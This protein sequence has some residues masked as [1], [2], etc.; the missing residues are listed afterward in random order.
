MEELHSKKVIFHR[1]HEKKKIESMRD[2]FERKDID[3]NI[4]Y[5]H[6]LPKR[7]YKDDDLS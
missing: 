6:S 3:C 4:G 2:D 5:L 7:L 1:D